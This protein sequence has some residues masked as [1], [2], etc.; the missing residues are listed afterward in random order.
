M[1]VVG[2]IVVV[3][4]VVVVVPVV[5]MVTLFQSW[6]GQKKSAHRC[7]VAVLDHSASCQDRAG[8]GSTT[9]LLTAS[10]D[11]LES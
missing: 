10:N 11:G 1:V 4:H 6:N 8:K 7:N 3:V 9:Y 2:D 5:E